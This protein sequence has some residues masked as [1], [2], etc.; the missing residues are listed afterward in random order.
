M[1][2]VWEFFE[3]MNEA[4]Y[5]SDVDTYE[6]IYLNKTARNL[7][8]LTPLTREGMYINCLKSYF[9][10]QFSKIYLHV[11][12]HSTIIECGGHCL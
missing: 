5:A 11:P 2:K 1:S 8:S 3:N 12:L 4:V 7:V 9:F 6:L 10:C